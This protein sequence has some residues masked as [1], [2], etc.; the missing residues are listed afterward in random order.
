MKIKW[1]IILLVFVIGLTRAKDEKKKNKNGGSLTNREK[2]NAT[3]TDNCLKQQKVPQK[4]FGKYKRSA[5]QCGCTQESRCLLFQNNKPV[6]CACLLEDYDV[7]EAPWGDDV[8]TVYNTFTDQNVLEVDETGKEKSVT[9]DM[10][11]EYMWQDNRIKTTFV[12]NKKRMAVPRNFKNDKLPIWSPG[13]SSNLDYLNEQVLK[14][15]VT[16]LAN[17]PFTPNATLVH[18]ILER[19]VTVLCSFD[20]SNYP[21]DTQHYQ[22]RLGDKR[23]ETVREILYDPENKAHSLKKYETDGFDMTIVFIGNTL[24]H[25]NPN[26]TNTFGFDIEMKRQIQPYMFQYY[27]PCISIVVVSS[28]SFVIPLSATPGRVALMVTLFL[29]L[30]NIFINQMVSYILSTLLNSF[31]NL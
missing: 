31:F 14:S 28:I 9:I 27:L 19:R 3:I 22:L 11:I 10:K 2:A 5:K 18:A 25:E 6:R 23:T 15:K 16:F 4:K 30:T 21:L 24:E 26:Y 7:T 20:Y 17:N 1:V 8:T 12:K 29:T 13:S